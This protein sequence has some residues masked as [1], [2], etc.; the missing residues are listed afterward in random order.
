MT[1][2]D[3]VSILA[4]ENCLLRPLEHIFTGQTVLDLDDADIRKIA[5]E[6]STTQR[7]RERI[8]EELEKLRKGRQALNAFSADGSSLRA[9][10]ILGIHAYF[11]LQ[12]NRHRADQNIIYQDKRPPEIQLLYLS[13]SRTIVSLKV[14]SGNS[15]D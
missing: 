10:P 5:A 13:P 6:P 1:F 14:G 2:I 11:N 9:P 4:I 3:N 8:T 12:V 7:D 15:H